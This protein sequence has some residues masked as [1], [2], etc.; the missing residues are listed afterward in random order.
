MLK[1]LS[2]RLKLR[3]IRESNSFW[4]A[5]GVIVGAYAVNLGMVWTVLIGWGI[6]VVTVLQARFFEEKAA[7]KVWLGNIGIAV[8]MLL[9]VL[10][11]T[12]IVP[13]PKPETIEVSALDKALDRFVERVTREAPTPSP[14]PM[15]VAATPLISPTPEL[16]ASQEPSFGDPFMEM[17]E[18]LFDPGTDMR[19]PLRPNWGNRVIVKTMNTGQTPARNVKT[20]VHLMLL[21]LK[22]GSEETIFRKIYDESK[23]GKL[24]WDVADMG[25]DEIATFNVQLEVQA[26]NGRYE[27]NDTELQEFITGQKAPYL[28][29]HIEYGK[30]RVYEKCLFLGRDRVSGTF[31]WHTCS[32][33]QRSH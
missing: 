16:P 14:T 12:A 8:V 7:I 1:N 24:K 20:F 13:R 29:I 2:L 4:T 6:L 11:I 22:N 17:K 31:E 9:F 26:P 23:A 18:A 32:T 33:H 30:D 25:R 28:G 19:Q 5:V 27:I 15:I 3:D 10:G 21:P